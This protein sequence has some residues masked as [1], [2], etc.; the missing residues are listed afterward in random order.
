MPMGRRCHGFLVVPGLILC[1][2]QDFRS[3][4]VADLRRAGLFRRRHRSALH[5]N[6]MT[7]LMASGWRC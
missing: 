6:L 4:V 5:E 2:S 3:L 1:G 7:A